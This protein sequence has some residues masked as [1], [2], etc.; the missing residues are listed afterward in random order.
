[1][2]LPT[3]YARNDTFHRTSPGPWR[4]PVM[5]AGFSFKPS[6]RGAYRDRV[7]HSYVVV[8]LL[9]G[10]GTYIDWQGCSHAISA[11]DV[12]VLLPDKPHT[13]E[14]EPDGQ[15][16][17]CW[18]VLDKGFGE[19]LAR[20]GVIDE[21]RLVM[22]CGVDLALIERFE[23]LLRDLKA[24]P[25]RA[26]PSQAP[27]V[28]ELLVQLRAHDRRTHHTHPHEDLVETACRHLGEDLSSRLDLAKRLNL[29][30]LSY[31]RFRKIFK[32]QTGVSPGEYRIR[33]RLDQARSLLAEGALSNKQIAYALG[34][35]D[36]FT[37][38]KQ[39]KQRLGIPPT[40]FRATGWGVRPR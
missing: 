38:S 4:A 16:T 15:W 1:M 34:Y 17:E 3:R 7:M 27:V 29:A 25:D 13:V 18:L 20:V 11:G 8:Y 30:G 6:A 39:F 9:R 40:C 12:L 10:R 32:H 36:P 26:I 19:A 5:G 22:T 23:R 33:R 2:V 31:E 21:T 14:Q 35:R 28:A 24:L 37:F